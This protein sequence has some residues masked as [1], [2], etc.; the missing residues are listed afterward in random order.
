MQRKEKEKRKIEWK[1]L[2]IY[3]GIYFI[4]FIFI[5]IVHVVLP[6]WEE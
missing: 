3:R 6:M 1:M 5:F 2:L 4:K